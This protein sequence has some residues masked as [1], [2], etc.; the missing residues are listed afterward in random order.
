MKRAVLFLVYFLFATL[1]LYAATIPDKYP[2]YAYVLS[3]FD[4]DEFYAY[5]RDFESYVQDH[6]TQFRQLYTQSVKRG[7]FLIP[8]V[9]RQLVEAEMSDLLAYLPMIESGFH[10]DI[11]SPKKAKGLWQFIPSTAKEYNLT[12]CYSYDER[13]DPVNAT[14]AAILHLQSLYRKFGKWYLAVMA[15]NCGEGRVTR[16]IK[17]AG[18]DELSVL[19]DDRAKYLP[20]ETREYIKRFLL[21]AMIGE[22]ESIDFG[23]FG[24]GQQQGVVQVE[25]NGGSDLKDIALLLNMEP[26][27]LI[28]LN[29][30]YKNE[31]L[32]RDSERY[33]ITIPYEKLILF[34]L[35]YHA[36][37]NVNKPKDH[38][39]SHFISAGETL[40]IIAEKYHTSVSEIKL[41]NKLKNTNLSQDSLLIIP[42]TKEQFESTV[43]HH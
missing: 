13:C 4:I 18:S 6:D 34:Y 20:K 17:K 29:S 8:M 28:E 7:E 33:K 25:V 43:S 36:V 42:V 39:I 30:H 21:V 15:Y 9:Q 23:T 16:A 24:S 27:Q 38:F 2:S 26:T 14:T 35:N 32:P 41:A 3:E 40:K 12:V 5:D 19:I 1:S 37:T 22:N 11:Q 10:T 31:I